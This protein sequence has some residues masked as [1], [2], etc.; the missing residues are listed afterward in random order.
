MP[1]PVPPLSHISWGG[2]AVVTIQHSKLS[3]LKAIAFYYSHTWR[4]KDCTWL[5][6]SSLPSSDSGTQEP[7]FVILPS[8]VCVFQGYCASLHPADGRG[9]RKGNGTQRA[10][11]HSD[12]IP[13]IRAPSLGHT[14]LQKEAGKCNPRVGPEGRENRFGEQLGSVSSDSFILP[15]WPL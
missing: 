8:S 9:R 2:W 7:Y 10:V 3:W 14:Y 6:G 5:A 13:R 1:L 12:H 4:P 11:H 15:S